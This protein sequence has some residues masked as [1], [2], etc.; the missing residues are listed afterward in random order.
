MKALVLAPFTDDALEA[1]Q[2]LLPITHESWTDTRRLYD[3]LELGE[4][5]TQEGITVLIIE[6]LTA[7][8]EDKLSS[9][10][11]FF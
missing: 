10:H 1:L 5:I 11:P 4:R 8:N 6:D 9:G 2:A 3:P 7:V